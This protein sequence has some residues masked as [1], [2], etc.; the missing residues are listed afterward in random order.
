M[1]VVVRVSIFVHRIHF[2]VFM[3]KTNALRTGVKQH[4]VDVLRAEV[5][6]VQSHILPEVLSL[7]NGDLLVDRRVLPRLGGLEIFREV[8]ALV[9]LNF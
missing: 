5:F 2:L 4:L 7:V 9:G 1:H 3:V 8:H 6:R